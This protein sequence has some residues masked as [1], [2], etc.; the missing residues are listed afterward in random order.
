MIERGGTLHAR[1]YWAPLHAL[2]KNY[3]VIAQL[4]GADGNA[5]AG[6][7]KQHP[8][9]PVV[10]GETPTTQIPSRRYLR[11]EHTIVIPANAPPGKYELRVG[12]YDPAT[13]K[14]LKLADG[15]TLFAV[16]TVEVR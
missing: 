13:G 15:G 14:R 7:D 3:H 8:G 5:I 16:G 12:L 6:S 4:I 9:D 1:V 2:A 11:D 10:Q